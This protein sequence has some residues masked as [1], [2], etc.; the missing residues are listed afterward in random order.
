MRKFKKSFFRLEALMFAAALLLH[1]NADAAPGAF[2]PADHAKPAPHGKAHPRPKHAGPGCKTKLGRDCKHDTT[3]EAF[4]FASQIRV[5]AGTLIESESVTISGI[6]H[7]TRVSID[8]GEYSIDGHAYRRGPGVIRNHQRVRIRVRSS[9]ESSGKVSATLTIGG[10]AGTFTVRTINFTGRV[11]AEAAN[12][13]DGASTVADGSASKGQAVF[14]G[15][16]GFGISTED[17]VDAR[18]LILAYRTDTAGTL[19]ATVNGASAGKFTLRPTAGVYATASLV[20]SVE[21]GDVIAIASPSTAA[22]SETYIDYVEF[23]DSPFRSVS[24]VATATEPFATDG[25]SVGPDGDIYVSGP[26]SIVRVT[27]EGD[28]SLFASG[29]VSANGSHFDSK[30]NLFVADYDGNAVRKITPDGVVTTFASGLNGPAGVW[31]DNNDNVLVSVFGAGFSGTGATV[32]KI[33]P[34][35]TVSTYASGAPLQ[36]VVT[37]VGDE[38]GNVYAA[39]WGSGTLFNITDGNVSVL[40]ETGGASNHVCYSHGYIYIPSPS[41]ALVRRVSVE[42]TV[43]TFIGTETRQTI[44]GPI[45]SADFERPNSCAFSADGTVLYVMDRENGLL[46]KVDAGMP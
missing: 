40:A 25:V 44:D 19:E 24:T 36:D 8:G 26:G 27:P 18:A 38:I 31:I 1:A 23:A 43:E 42:G 2:C 20:V 3:P 37:I 17:S 16:A 41:S 6:N 15:S 5:A 29:L 35:G 4:S 28:V 30:G 22:G 34:D 33:T 12:L 9:S 10:V 7:P 11:E 32:L 14:V 21:V 45:A 46:R 13:I 39:N